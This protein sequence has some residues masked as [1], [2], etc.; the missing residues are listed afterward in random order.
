MAKIRLTDNVIDATGVAKNKGTARTLQDFINGLGEIQ[1]GET[2]RDTGTENTTYTKPGSTAAGTRT[3]TI[4]FP[5]PFST[6]PDVFITYATGNPDRTAAAQM[7][8]YVS[9]VTTTNFTITGTVTNDYAWSGSNVNLL[10]GIFW[11]AIA[12]VPKN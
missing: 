8:M 4:T 1:A 12:G 3:R 5:K 11:V 2:N 6:V 7:Q 9:N 10:C